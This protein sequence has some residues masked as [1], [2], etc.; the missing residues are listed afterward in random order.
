MADCP[1]PRLQANEI[2]EKSL[3]DSAASLRMYGRRTPECCWEL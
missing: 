3:A 1:G 2:L